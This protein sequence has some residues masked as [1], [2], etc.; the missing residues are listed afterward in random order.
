MSKKPRVIITANAKRDVRAIRDLIA[1]DRPIA[2]AKWVREFQRH[3]RILA[4]AP[5]AF[6]VIPEAD[7]IGAPYRHLLFGN[8]RIV[9]HVA[10][11]EV[12]VVMVIHAAR[13]LTRALLPPR[14]T[15]EK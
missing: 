12:A 2:A 9:Y 4:S 13:K 5:L 15:S 10:P 7:Q 14:P 8:Y 6:E 1:R 3:A 11:T